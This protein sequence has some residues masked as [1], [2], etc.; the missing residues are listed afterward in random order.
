MSSVLFVTHFAA[1]CGQ[2]FPLTLDEPYSAVIVGYGQFF[3]ADAVQRPQDDF[4]VG[5]FDVILRL[6]CPPP[7]V[8]PSERL[9]G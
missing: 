4:V 9:L 7:I 6:E 1:L 5:Q 3:V 2:F 8:E